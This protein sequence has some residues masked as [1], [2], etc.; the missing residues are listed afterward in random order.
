MSAAEEFLSQP[1]PVSGKAD[2]VAFVSDNQTLEV[3]AA[4]AGNFFTD[5]LVRDGGSSE[6]LQYLSEAEQPKVMIIDIGD[7]EDPLSSLLTLS[8]AI[9]EGGVWSESAPSTTSRF[10]A[11]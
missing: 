9:P 5:P 7:G 2:C 11:S 4:A 1:F 8:T 3:V 10:I 6:A